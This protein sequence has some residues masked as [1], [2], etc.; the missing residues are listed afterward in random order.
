M[1]LFSLAPIL[2]N[3]IHM[4]IVLLNNLVTTF[5]L[6]KAANHPYHHTIKKDDVM[7]E[8]IDCV[9]NPNNLLLTERID[10]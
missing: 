2:H 6:N 10:L 5:L 1:Q 8:M 9:Y 7:T 4:Y 3:L